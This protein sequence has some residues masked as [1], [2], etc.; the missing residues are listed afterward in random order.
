MCGA[1]NIWNR[2]F[3]EDVGREH[4]MRLSIHVDRG[5]KRRLDVLAR[6]S[7]RSRSLLVAEAIA[8][9]VDSEEGQLDEIH[10]G[11]AELGVSKS[12]ATR[13]W[14]NGSNPGEKRVRQRRRDSDR[15]VLRRI[16]FTYGRTP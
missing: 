11:I 16:R 5:T 8:A 3:C 1:D 13:G 9:Y 4:N 12:S 7:K 10:A 15:R 6:L 2:R 14:R